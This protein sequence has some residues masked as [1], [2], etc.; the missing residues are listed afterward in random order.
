MDWSFLE[1]VLMQKTCWRFW[2][3]RMIIAA[4]TIW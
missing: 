1:K 2:L 4:L 3:E